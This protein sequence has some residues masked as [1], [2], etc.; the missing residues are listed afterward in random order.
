MTKQ[1]DLRTTRVTAGISALMLSAKAGLN[2]SSLSLIENGHVAPSAER[3]AALWRAL[4]EL[5][6]SKQR[7]AAA[8]KECHWPVSAL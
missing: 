3:M 4:D 8:A 5:I 6:A 2:R 1:D 7:M